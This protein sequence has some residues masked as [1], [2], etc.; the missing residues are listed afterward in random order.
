MRYIFDNDLHIH[1][2]LSLCSKDERQ[3]PESILQYAKDNGLK[4]VA[5]TDH[6]W[7]SKI[8][9]ASGF[10]TPQNFEWVSRSKPLPQADGIRFLFGCETDLDK[11]MRL[12]MPKERFED[13][14]FIVIPVTHLHMK[15]FTISEEDAASA[16]GRAR[17][18]LERFDFVLGMD[19]PFEKIGFA[20]L[21]TSLIAPT[22]DEYLKVLSLLPEEKLCELFEK[23]AKLGAGIELNA[24]DMSFA[25]NE[26]E[27]VLRIF[28]IAKKCG[29]KFYMGSDAHHPQEF[30][31]VNQVFARAIDMLA[32]T[33]DDKFKLL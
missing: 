11:N 4:T 9:G 26:A 2:Y 18:W 1:S 32:L 5:L 6:Y 25:P 31:K 33:E 17:V 8:E 7:D 14:D 27:T 3:N 21:A 22:R 28:K 16:E 12:G 23:C 10:Y 19:L 13:F 24:S 30:E 29:C 15:G 20:H